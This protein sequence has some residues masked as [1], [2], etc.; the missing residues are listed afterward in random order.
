MQRLD[1]HPSVS[2]FTRINR[3]SPTVLTCHV[4]RIDPNEWLHRG[5]IT[6]P[7]CPAS[8]S[9]HRCER[10]L[11]PGIVFV[12]I[13]SPVSL[14]NAGPILSWVHFVRTLNFAQA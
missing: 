13:C 14:A 4:S 9:R 12:R 10:A 7:P 6:Q 8:E 5:P 3:S 2:V 11:L 1:L